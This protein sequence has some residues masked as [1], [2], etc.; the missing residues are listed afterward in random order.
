MSSYTNNLESKLW[1][2]C[3]ELRGNMDAS[4]FMDEDSEPV[5]IF[6]KRGEKYHSKGCTFLRAA[7]TSAALSGTIRKKYKACPLCHSSRA[8]DGSLV[9]YFPS[10]GEDFHLPGCP[11]LQRNYIE[12]DK[13]TALRR[14]YTSCSKCGG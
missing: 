6:P 8:A 11:A 1:A 3:N 2:T 7:S 5:F 14:G 12:I 13:G 10:D 4:E 9:Y